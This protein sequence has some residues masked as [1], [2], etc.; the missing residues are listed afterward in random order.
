V[1]RYIFYSAAD[2]D[3][4]VACSPEEHTIQEQ[5]FCIWWRFKLQA[6]LNYK[7]SDR[8]LESRPK[9]FVEEY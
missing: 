6:F 5:K 8:T 9:A 3:N 7:F 4:F 1:F 2:A